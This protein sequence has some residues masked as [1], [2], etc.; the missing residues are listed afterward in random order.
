MMQRAFLCDL[1]FKFI[2][3]VVQASGFM[4]CPETVLLKGSDP[5][6]HVF[7]LGHGLQQVFQRKDRE[8]ISVRHI[9]ILQTEKQ[10]EIL[11]SKEKSS[12]LGAP[13]WLSR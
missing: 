7:L 9:N 2:L 4:L 11:I 5:L 12:I 10:G 3:E 13:G 6:L 8:R 1:V